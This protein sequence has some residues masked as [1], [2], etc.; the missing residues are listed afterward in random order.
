[1]VDIRG[2]CPMG[3]GETLSVLDAYPLGERIECT[4]AA[5]PDPLA[6]TKI[7]DDPETEHIVTIYTATFT[8]R[9]PLRERI[10]N[11]L[12]HC[13]MHQR[14]VDLDEPPVP[15]GTY[16]VTVNPDGLWCWTAV[17]A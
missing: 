7:L 16:R 11:G 14:L 12:D 6:A 9:H 17:T 3:C 8:I 13:T 15:P 2:Y 5:C 10:G 1:M 4:E